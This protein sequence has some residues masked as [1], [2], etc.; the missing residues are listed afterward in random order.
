VEGIH[1]G[2]RVGEFFGSGG[3]E[4]SETVHRHHLD[5]IAPGFGAGGEPRLERLLR[6]SLDQQEAWDGVRA[7]VRRRNDE[8]LESL[9]DR[10]DPLGWR[11]AA[12]AM[13]QAERDQ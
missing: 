4:A 9:L 10:A 6:T 8:A 5:A 3:L 7:E 13:Q 12:R 1:H 11:A 2:H